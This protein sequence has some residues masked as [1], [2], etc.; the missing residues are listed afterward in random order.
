[1]RTLRVEVFGDP[2]AQGSKRAFVV[3]Q[4]AVVVDTNKASL[5]TW[6]SDI[7][8]AARAELDGDGPFTGP[9]NV[10]AFFWLRQPKK[11]K[12]R[13]PGVRPDV[14]KLLRA[15]LDALTAAGVF[16]DDAQVTSISARKRYGETPRCVIAVS[17]DE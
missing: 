5:R 4:R 13:L 17:E 14:D 1:M 16:H 9:V 2:V 3:G 10:V 12:W 6:R 7:V 11:P 15:L 8:A